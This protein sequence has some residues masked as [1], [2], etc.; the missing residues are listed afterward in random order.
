[1]LP[2]ANSRDVILDFLAV[3][4]HDRAA[5]AELVVVLDRMLDAVA[6]NYSVEHSFEGR[7]AGLTLETAQVCTVLQ[8]LHHVGLLRTVT[9]G[10]A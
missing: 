5:L 10:G 1:V 2:D 4:G 8:H 9:G 3:E 7:F 6:F